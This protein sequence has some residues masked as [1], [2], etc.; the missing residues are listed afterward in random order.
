[1]IKNSL[2]DISK[3]MKSWAKLPF[4]HKVEGRAYTYAE[5][6]AVMEKVL[7]GW[8]KTEDQRLG[9][10]LENAVYLDNP[11]GKDIFYV[12]DNLLAD[13]AVKYA[14]GSKHGEKK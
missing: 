9:Q 14:E 1:M 6:R 10:F 3:V 11:E 8:A 2:K 4:S 5:K 7:A 12:E 13:L